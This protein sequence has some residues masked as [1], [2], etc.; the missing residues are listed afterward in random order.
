MTWRVARSLLTLREEIDDRWPD[1]ER[2]SDG[3]IGDESHQAKANRSDHNPWVKDDNGVGVVRA[4]DVDAGPGLFPNR[5]HDTVGDTVSEVVRGAGLNGHPA[6][7]NGA[8]VI[9]E[10]RIASALSNP[11][12]SWRK[13]DG[14]AHE[15][16]PHI[17][18]GRNEA[19]F[20]SK[21]G[22]G[23]RE[24]ARVQ[25]PATR[26]PLS[27]DFPTL[28]LG[29][30]GEFVKLVQRFLWGSARAKTMPVY[31]TFED[32]TDSAVR[33]YQR[34]RGLTVDGRVGTDTWAPIRS[35][36]HI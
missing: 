3:T 28:H 32:T 7:G 22:W 18:V 4:L 2:Q 34:M 15:S 12:W 27:T 25:T 8:Y 24:H 33:A 1:R 23:I 13:H 35:A 10:G 17:S 5:S 26:T 30:S 31:G 11:A 16:H 20:D 6:L 36:L 21:A 29:S 9:Y 14:D 19:A